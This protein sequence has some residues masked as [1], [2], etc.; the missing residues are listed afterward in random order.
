MLGTMKANRVF[1]DSRG[2]ALNTNPQTITILRKVSEIKVATL[3]LLFRKITFFLRKDFIVRFWENTF[4]FL[5]DK[6]VLRKLFL[7][8]NHFF[9]NMYFLNEAF[10]WKL[11]FVYSKALSGKFYFWKPFLKKNFENFYFIISRFQSPLKTYFDLLFFVKKKNSFFVFENCFWK[12]ISKKTE[13]WFWKQIFIKEIFCEKFFLFIKIKFWKQFLYYFE[14]SFESIFFFS[15]WKQIL[16]FE[17]SFF[18]FL[19]RKKN[20]GFPFF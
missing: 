7:F 2:W 8:E 19:E 14:N 20:F 17:N 12:T 4:S 3:T 15:F 16:Y 6:S 5:H 1:K 13:F 18:F 11:I 9:E 10:F